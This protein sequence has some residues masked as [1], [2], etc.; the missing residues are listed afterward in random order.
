MNIMVKRKCPDEKKMISI[1]GS[2]V[3][4]KRS[5]QGVRNK[6]T[7]RPYI[8]IVRYDKWCV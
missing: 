1:G 6:C 7:A 2:R 3:S 5:K 4:N 8:I